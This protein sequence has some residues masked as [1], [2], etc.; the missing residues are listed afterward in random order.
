M[1]GKYSQKL[2]DHNKQST[3][4]SLKTAS[5]KAI[6]KKSEATADLICN[7]TANKIIKV[8]RPSSHIR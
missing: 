6:Q 7:K 5:K 2:L 3:T 8:S 4:Y 1:R